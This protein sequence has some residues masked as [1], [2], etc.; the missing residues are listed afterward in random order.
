MID[1]KTTEFEIQ[2]II[3]NNLF[4]SKSMNSNELYQHH[5]TPDTQ[6]DDKIPKFDDGNF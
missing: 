2:R 3:K 4:W 6:I 5:S 1:T